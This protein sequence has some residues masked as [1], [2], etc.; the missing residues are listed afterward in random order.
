LKKK[1][2]TFAVCLNLFKLFS[3]LHP[4]RVIIVD[5]SDF[6]KCFTVCYTRPILW[7]R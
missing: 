7:T 5:F 1:N 4:G 6:S 3:L 2:R